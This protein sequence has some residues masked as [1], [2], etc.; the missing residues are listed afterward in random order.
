LPAYDLKPFLTLAEACTTEG[1]KLTLHS[2]DGHFFLRVN[3]QPLMGTNAS[4]SE[5]QLAELACHRLR[6]R[7]GV[8]VLIG[9]LGFG[10]SLR[11]V[12]EMVTKDSVAHVAELSP[13]VV[14]WNREFLGAVNGKLID[15][16]RV[17]L[18]LEDVFEVMTRAET[19]SYDAILLDVDNGPIAMVKD[20]NAR[21]YQE[22]GFAAI[23][24]VLKPRGRVTFW[25]ASRDPAFAKRLVK[26]GF[27]VDAV[28]VKAYEKARRNSHTIFVA[29]RQT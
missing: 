13:E 29:D 17:Q 20:G 14:R 15:D 5:M 25:S 8:R 21:L 18:S 12:L 10:F 19:A 11:R 2:H 3:R 26:A 28:G 27:K 4:L 22:R 24:R 9:G 6:G 16:P 23:M 7:R 1:A